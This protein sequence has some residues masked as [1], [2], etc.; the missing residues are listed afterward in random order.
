MSHTSPHLV[1]PY[2]RVYHIL[3]KLFNALLNYGFSKDQN[4][5]FKSLKNSLNKDGICSVGEGLN[6]GI[7]EAILSA[8]SPE[9]RTPV[10][11]PITLVHSV[12]PLPEPRFLKAEM[13]QDY[14]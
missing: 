9:P 14:H 13:T 4:K 8:L 11:P 10:S 12:F 3:L 1:L 7:L 5:N 6:T 2:E